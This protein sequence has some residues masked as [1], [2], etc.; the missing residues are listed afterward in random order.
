MTEFDNRSVMR[1]ANDLQRTL[2][3]VGDDA[4]RGLSAGFERGSQTVERA[5]DKAPDAVGRLNIAQRR[6]AATPQRRNAER[7]GTARDGR[8]SAGVRAIRAQRRHPRRGNTTYALA[9]AER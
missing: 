2:Q 6:N 1:S 3:R 4:G 5:M 8:G 9:A 7:T